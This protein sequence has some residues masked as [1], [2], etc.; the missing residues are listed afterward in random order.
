[1]DGHFRSSDKN[2]D[3][4]DTDASAS[5]NNNNNIPANAGNSIDGLSGQQFRNLTKLKPN[6]NPIRK[7]Q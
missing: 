4:E 1:M 5:S 6:Q 3:Q 7:H 2:N